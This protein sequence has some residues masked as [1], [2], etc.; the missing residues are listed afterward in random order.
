MN[1]RAIVI[2]RYGGPEVLTL[3]EIPVPTV[4]P[5][6]VLI[7]LR[8]AGVNPVDALIRS[9]AFPSFPLP[10]IVGVDL[11]GDIIEVGQLSETEKALHDWVSSFFYDRLM[12]RVSV[13]GSA[14][15]F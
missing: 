6:D 4:R 5:G 3:R 10:Y 2:D 11:A 9:G 7:R 15:F 1:M 14:M 12:G 8:A 13:S